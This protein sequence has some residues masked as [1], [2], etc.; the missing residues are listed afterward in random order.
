MPIDERSHAED[1]YLGEADVAVL[2]AVVG[3]PYQLPTIE[4][5]RYAVRDH[6][7]SVVDSRLERLV[8]RG[9]LELVAFEDGPPLPDQPDTF[10]GTTSFGDEVLDQRLS[11]DQERALFESYAR[12]DKPDRV[13]AAERAPRPPR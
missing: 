5:V 8:E 3:H 7:E 12:L 10:Y 1:I 9:L 2:A 13:R 11:T 4:E 6:D